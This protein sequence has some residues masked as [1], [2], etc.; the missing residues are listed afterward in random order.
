MS[1]GI[2][3]AVCCFTY[4]SDCLIKWFRDVSPALGSGNKFDTFWLMDALPETTALY[5]F[6][7][8]YDHITSFARCFIL[9]TPQELPLYFTVFGLGSCCRWAQ[10]SRGTLYPVGGD[11]TGPVP[12]LDLVSGHPPKGAQQISPEFIS[13][14]PTSRS[15][16][17]GLASPLLLSVAWG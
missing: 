1:W 3:T 2:F 14:L 10:L 5:A 4:I 15:L 6:Y 13:G 9:M 11:H 16:S 8:F 17:V 7:A 12:F